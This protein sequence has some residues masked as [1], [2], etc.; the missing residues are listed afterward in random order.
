MTPSAIALVHAACLAIVL[1]MGAGTA[2]AAENLPWRG[3]AFSGNRAALEKLAASG[4]G[5]VRTY[6]EKD[7]WVLDEARKLG[8]EVVFGLEIGLPRHGFRLDDDE[9]LARQEENLRELVLRYRDHPALLA[10]GIGNEVDMGM[11]DPLPMWR[12]VDRLAMVIEEL[13]PAHPIIMSV[14]DGEPERLRMLSTCCEHIDLIGFN[15]YAGAAFNFAQRIRDAG[16]TRPLAITEL[17][18]L[19]QWQ[20]GRKPWGAPVELSSREKADFFRRAIAE[21]ERNPQIKGIFPF[22]WGAKQ[23]QTDTWHG[24]LLSDGS[25]TEMTDALA[26]AWGRPPAIPAPTILGIGIAA[27]E[28]APREIV[29]VGIDIRHA[30]ESGVRSTGWLVRAEATELAHGG[31]AEPIPPAIGVEVLTADTT[32][33]RFRAPEIPGA[34]RLFI[35]VRDGHGKAATANLPFR[36]RMK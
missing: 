21:L 7:A 9:A 19:G 25:L 23:E 8:L 1:A 15:L 36:V 12:E 20:A 32:S 11:D 17:G 26:I 3:A 6:S 2:G 33:V 24:L 5:V 35:T 14:A 13:D 31:D 30:P 34:Y 4:A 18:P 29:S 22:L 10:W 27:D 28:F 16:L